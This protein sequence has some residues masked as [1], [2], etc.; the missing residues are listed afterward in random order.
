MQTMT[1]AQVRVIALQEAVKTVSTKPVFLGSAANPQVV[2]FTKSDVLA[3]AKEYESYVLYGKK[4]DVV[5]LKGQ[6]SN[7]GSQK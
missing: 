2:E 4:L 5:K 3:I 6:K 7:V 1:P